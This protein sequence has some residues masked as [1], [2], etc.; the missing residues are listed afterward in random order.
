MVKCLIFDYFDD[1]C[2]LNQDLQDFR[3]CRI[4]FSAIAGCKPEFLIE[5]DCKS[6][7]TEMKICDGVILLFFLL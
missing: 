3:I 5:F 4:V 2:C 1:Y 7:T 6:N